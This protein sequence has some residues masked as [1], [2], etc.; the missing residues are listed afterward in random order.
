M[1]IGEKAQNLIIYNG[2]KLRPCDEYFYVYLA[3]GT[4]KEVDIR[5]RYDVVISSRVNSLG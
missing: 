5:E 3:E 4:S 1:S 2:N